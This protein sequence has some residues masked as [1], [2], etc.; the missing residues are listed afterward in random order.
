VAEPDYVVFD[1]LVERNGGGHR[2]RVLSSPAGNATADLSQALSEEQ[3]QSFLFRVGR[4]RQVSRR[5][6]SS[7]SEETRKFGAQLFDFLFPSA[8]SACLDRSRL[9]AEAQGKGLRIQIRLSD[10]PDLCD[11][12]WEFL[13]E[14]DAGFLAL[15]AQTPIVRFL[16]GKQAAQ[17]I[18]VTHP[19]RI[20]VVISNPSDYAHLDID[21]EWGKLQEAVAPLVAKGLVEIERLDAPRLSRLNRR[22][23]NETFHVLHFIG[24]GDYDQE[25]QAGGLYF[26]DERGHAVRVSA[27]Q[28][29]TALRDHHSIRLVILNSCEGARSSRADPFA[30]TAQT[31]IR[32]GIP[33]VI[34]MQFEVTDDAAV[35]FATEFYA[36]I[37]VGDPV[38]RSLTEA[39]RAMYF[40]G[41]ELEWATPVL[42]LRSASGRLFSVAETALVEEQRARHA[43]S[44]SD[45]MAAPS[46]DASQGTG[47]AAQAERAGEAEDRRQ[48]EAAERARRDAEALR[49]AK[50]EEGR[51]AEAAARLAEERRQAAASERARQEAIEAEERRN[52]EVARSSEAP[53]LA[54]RWHALPWWAKVSLFAFWPFGVIWL[55]TCRDTKMPRWLIYSIIGF[56]ILVTIYIA[57]SG[58]GSH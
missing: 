43:A 20:L 42:Y 31:M 19:L 53:S 56:W 18:A 49:Q 40:D 39:R 46:L 5:G 47:A 36:S 27:E 28:I 45:A 38:D 48:A 11:L 33:A 10:V 52:R 41:N 37:V 23:R 3:L 29:G 55:V 30:G 21:R 51:L 35:T 17:S 9:A 25:R 58:D 22:L 2:A 4:P 57:A 54:V 34:A 13:Y 44:R 32:C 8:I 15:T 14:R 12:P 24:H 26:E 1:L 6:G 7:V 50:V 16:E